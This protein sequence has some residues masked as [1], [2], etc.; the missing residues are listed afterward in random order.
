MIYEQYEKEQQNSEFKSALAVEYL[1]GYQN[2]IQDAVW[3][4][5]LEER[6]SYG[7]CGI[8]LGYAK[9][10]AFAKNI[11]VHGAKAAA[12]PVW[13][14]IDDD[15]M[16]HKVISFE[17]VLSHVRKAGDALHVDIWYPSQSGV[18]AIEIGLIDVRAAD[19]IR[20][21]YDYHR[22]GWVIKRGDKEVLFVAE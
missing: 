13:N 15:D 11:L 7:S 17:F 2:T 10:S 9:Y 6:Q 16:H 21:E 1:D 14:G 19:D 4:L 20:V 8:E 3:N 12:P 18:K 5:A 22:D